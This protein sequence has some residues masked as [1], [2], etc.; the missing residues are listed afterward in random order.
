[1]GAEITIRLD[2]GSELNIRK[3]SH[4]YLKEADGHDVHWEWQYVTDA[5][6]KL[7][8]LFTSAA[9]MFSRARKALPDLPKTGI[10]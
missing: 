10:K 1:M 6:R 5:D 2:D 7:E 9:E 4:I 3:G 8:P